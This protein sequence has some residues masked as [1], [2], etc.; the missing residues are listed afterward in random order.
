MFHKGRL[1]T[2]NLLTRD[3]LPCI[4][5]NSLQKKKKKKKSTSS[6]FY[7]PSKINRILQNDNNL[8]SF[9]IVNYWA[10]VTS[11]FQES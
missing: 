2:E 3:Y 11:A 8:P 7:T 4:I 10:T 9:S 1:A 5:I 6:I